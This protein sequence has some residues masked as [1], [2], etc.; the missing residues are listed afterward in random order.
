MPVPRTLVTRPES[1]A[2]PWVAALQARGLRAQA[3]PLIAIAA[4]TDAAALAMAA[5]YGL[6]LVRETMASAAPCPAPITWAKRAMLA[7]GREPCPATA[8]PNQSTS[9]SSVL[10]TTACGRCSKRRWAAKAASWALGVGMRVLL[11]NF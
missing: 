8:E 4:P 3:L 7:T 1:E 5:Q 9:R 11:V 6:L 2:A 10:R